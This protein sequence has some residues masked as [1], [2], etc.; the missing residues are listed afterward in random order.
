MWFD[1][2]DWVPACAGTTKTCNRF[3]MGKNNPHTGSEFD[4]F[5]KEE[6]IFKEVQ[7]NALQ[8]ALADRD[9]VPQHLV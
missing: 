5:L 9:E 3:G 6:G 2:E 7:A 1:T 8:R 4:D